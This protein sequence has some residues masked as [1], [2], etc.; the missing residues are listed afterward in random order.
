M[1]GH[2]QGAGCWVG[3]QILTYTAFCE[4]SLDQFAGT[5]ASKGY[6]GFKVS[7]HQS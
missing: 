7:P 4:V 2:H 5:A 3:A 1:G 6:F